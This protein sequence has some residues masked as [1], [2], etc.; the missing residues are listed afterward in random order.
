M[1]TN[2]PVL[3]NNIQKVHTKLIDITV[4]MVCGVFVKEM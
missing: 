2:I 4:S 1:G 3:G